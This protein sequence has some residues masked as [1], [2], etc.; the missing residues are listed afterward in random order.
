MTRQEIEAIA[1]RI[2]TRIR[3]KRARLTGKDLYSYNNLTGDTIV[4][5]NRT[6]AALDRNNIEEATYFIQEAHK[7]WC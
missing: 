3:A 1:K 2:A 4:W 7:C 5:L 6:R